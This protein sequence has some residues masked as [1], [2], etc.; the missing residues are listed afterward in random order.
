MKTPYTK[1][2]QKFLESVATTNA[3][4]DRVILKTSTPG[5]PILTLDDIRKA[6]Q[7]MEMLF[8]AAEEAEYMIQQAATHEYIN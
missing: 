5:A 8:I 6:V 3:A 7:E 4:E 1:R 2:V